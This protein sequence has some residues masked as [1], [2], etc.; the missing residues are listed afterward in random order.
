MAS[1]CPSNETQPIENKSRY[2]NYRLY[3]VHFEN[4]EQVKVFQELEDRSDSCIFIGHARAPGQKLSILVAAHKVAD[5]TDLLERF[6][7]EHEI[8]VSFFIIK[9]HYVT[10]ITY[11]F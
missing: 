9:I 8:L 6:H 3:H 2:D 5:V 11:I 7:I 1:I 4:D 10:Y